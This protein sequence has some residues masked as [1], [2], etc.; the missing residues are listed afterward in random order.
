MKNI[1]QAEAEI[2]AEILPSVKSPLSVFE[3]SI[4]S[5]IIERAKCKFC[6]LNLNVK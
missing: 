2:K 6:S 1:F 5:H 4:E 3:R